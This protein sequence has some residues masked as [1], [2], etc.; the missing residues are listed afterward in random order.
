MGA[1]GTKLNI[2]FAT[3]ERERERERERFNKLLKTK[4]L[5]K[6]F[7]EKRGTSSNFS[8]KSVI[9]IYV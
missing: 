1:V 7:V 3:R 8:R 2:E 6:N 4:T 5:N 9:A